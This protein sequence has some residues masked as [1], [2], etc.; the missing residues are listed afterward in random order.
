M[1]IKDVVEYLQQSGQPK[2]ARLV[3]EQTQMLESV[4]VISKHNFDA[5]NALREKYEPIYRIGSNRAP[6]E[7]DG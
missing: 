5:F 6:A 7:S 2:M 1:T 4:R 3:S